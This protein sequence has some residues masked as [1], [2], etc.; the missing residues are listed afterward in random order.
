[1]STPEPST[2]DAPRAVVRLTEDAIA[3][4]HRLHRKDPQI[5]RWAFKK[6]LLLERSVEA[7]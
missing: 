4:L 7:G 2:P 3:D 5:V 1:M 6:M